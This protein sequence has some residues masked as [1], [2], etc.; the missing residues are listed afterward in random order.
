MGKVDESVKPEGLRG[1]QASE[2]KGVTLNPFA[3]LPHPL[4]LPSCKAAVG[5]QLKVERLGS[6]WS[7]P[8]FS[9]QIFCSPLGPGQSLGVEMCSVF[10][11]GC[12][13]KTEREV[14]VNM[15]K[16]QAQER[17]DRRW[18]VTGLVTM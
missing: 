6:K 12:G 11:C 8:T 18:A 13:G 16:A 9:S 10:H 2:L 15:K 14:V 7:K 3:L 5:W 1:F 4:P 17:G